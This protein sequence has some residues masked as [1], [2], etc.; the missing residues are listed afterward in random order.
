[1]KVAGIT[2]DDGIYWSELNISPLEFDFLELDIR[3]TNPQG[4]PI[5][6]CRWWERT[7]GAASAIEHKTGTA[8]TLVP[9]TGDNGNN[10]HTVGLQLSN[11]W[12]WFTTGSIKSLFLE[13][14]PA[15]E[16]E[17]RN[18]QLVASRLL[19][20][21]LSVINQQASPTG[22]YELPVSGV[23][24]ALRIDPSLRSQECRLEVSKPNYFFDNFQSHEQEETIG[25]VITAPAGR[26]T[27][28]LD[29]DHFASPGYYQIRARLR[30][31]SGNAVG[32]PSDC[33]TILADR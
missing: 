20:A 30:D 33:I 24:L 25:E 6:K 13:L 22:I 18:I 16:I 1:M 14:P 23:M 26:Q 7:G 3:L 27:Y 8:S 29:P 5:L 17:L 31:R 12:R 28:R 19:A 2:A 4:R 21:Q 9:V 11:H 10:F 15:E 32:E